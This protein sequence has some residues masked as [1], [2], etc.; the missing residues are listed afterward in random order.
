MYHFEFDDRLLEDLKKTIEIAK[1]AHAGQVDKAGKPYF[2]HVQTV[3]ELANEIILSWNEEYDDFLIQAQI[4]SYLHDV[5]EDTSLT[6]DDLWKLQVP[7]DCILAIETLTKRKGQDYND[8]LS[9]VKLN[10]LATVVKIADLTHNSDLSRLNVVTPADL[11]QHDKYL[12][13]IDYLSNYTCEKCGLSSNVKNMAEKSTRSNEILCK[14]CLE[15]YEIIYD[16]FEDFLA[17]CSD[18]SGW[19]LD[20][21]GNK[22][23][24]EHK[25]KDKNQWFEDMR[26][27]DEHW[28]N[29]LKKKK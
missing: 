22:V 7:T 23:Y 1:S 24:I 2:E 15:N 4:V 9:R 6:I 3:S 25:A 26:K 13:A 5:V 14:A 11:A 27:K 29:W 12:K 16:E 18:W 17:E 8:Y 19:E 21:K 10:K 28:Q 20:D